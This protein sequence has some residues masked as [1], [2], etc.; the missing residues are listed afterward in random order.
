MKQFGHIVQIEPSEEVEYT[1][2][3]AKSMEL[4][5]TILKQNQLVLETNKTLVEAMFFP[6]MLV[7]PKAK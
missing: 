6:P 4:A 3:A 7:K 2:V 5:N 1:I